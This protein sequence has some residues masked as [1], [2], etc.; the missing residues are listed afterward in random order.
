[1]QDETP[2]LYEAL[3]KVLLGCLGQQQDYDRVFY[4]TFLS[5][6]VEQHQSN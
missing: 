1:M 4:R 3:E 6:F 2:S 5:L